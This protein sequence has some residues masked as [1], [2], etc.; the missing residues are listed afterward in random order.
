MRVRYHAAGEGPVVVLL[1]GV[2]VDHRVWLPTARRLAAAARVIVP[3]LP[4]AGASE[5][6][7]RYPFTREALADTVCDLLAGISA[8]RAHVA[9][10]GMGALVALTLAADRGEVVDRVAAVSPALGEGASLRVR[11]PAAP[12]VGPFVFKQLYNRAVL[13]GHLRGDVFAPGFRCD[14]ALVDAWYDAFTTPEAREC[15]WR[16]LVHAQADT[17]ALGP[18]LRK[19]R[20]PT[21][22]LWG[23]RAPRAPVTAAQRLAHELPAGRLEMIR[24]AGHAPPLER[25]EATAEA[26]AR[27]FAIPL[28]PAGPGDVEASG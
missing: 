14:P 23:D 7:T 5:K 9:G 19:V 3:D 11:V 8:P 16:M 21:L 1:H 22:V 13:Q 25:P 20:A 10:L 26:L 6:P 2:F 15:Q 27:H 17:D 24:G 4:G 28:P 12:V 18:R